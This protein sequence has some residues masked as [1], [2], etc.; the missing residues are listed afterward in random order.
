[1]GLYTERRKADDN[2]LVPVWFMRQAGRY[3]QHYQER[4]K[5]YSFME[6]C[7]TPELAA[8]ITLGPIEDFQFD[9][10]ILFSD[11]L[12]PLE[13]LGMGLHYNDGPPKLEFHLD[14]PEAVNKLKVMEESSTFYGFQR[15]ALALLKEKLPKDV[16][17]LGFTGAPFTLYTYAACGSHGGSLARAKEGLYDGTFQEFMKLLKPLIVE[18]LK[19]QIKGKADG[20]C[21]FD[22][23]A[24]ELC[25][26]DYETHV[27]P[28]LK[29]V[30]EEI[31]A[32][33]SDIK[34]TYYSRN[35]GPDFFDLLTDLPIDVLGVDWRLNFE[36]VI[37]KYSSHF[38][39][40]GNIDPCWLFLPWE[41][42]EKNLNEFAASMKA[43]E[44]PFDRWVFGLGHGVLPGTPEINVKN[45]VK[46]VREN[47]TY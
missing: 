43:A 42:L 36:K 15:E 18:Q 32:Y 28:H 21:L 25:P 46:W 5:K 30:M 31:K 34:I 20:L 23:A 38:Y 26:R 29:E 33:S 44:A 41:K 35:T 13:Q 2:T 4:R 7:K 47:L 40:Q 19:E 22:T 27:L 9:A 14:S 12:F 24:G 37:K 1:M 10:A 16:T 6:M 11:L 45:T 17:L 3:H 8:E 39:I